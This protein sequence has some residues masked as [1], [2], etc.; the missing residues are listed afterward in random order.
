MTTAITHYGSTVYTKYAVG[1]ARPNADDA[2]YTRVT[3]KWEVNQKFTS[4]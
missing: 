2:L 3:S 4:V 1:E